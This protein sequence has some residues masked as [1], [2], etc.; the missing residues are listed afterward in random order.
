MY[1]EGRGK[2]LC[3]VWIRCVR[4]LRWVGRVWWWRWQVVR[5][6][7][8]PRGLPRVQAALRGVVSSRVGVVALGIRLLVEAVQ[9]LVVG[10]VVGFGARWLLPPPQVVV[11]PVHGL[12]AC[13]VGWWAVLVVVWLVVVVVVVVVVLVML[14]AYALVVVVVAVVVVF[15]VLVAVVVVV[16]VVP[17]VVVVV[18]L[19]LCPHDP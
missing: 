15:G 1:G 18:V 12:W 9:L 8:Y 5:V 3:P 16:V 14:V 4:G 6:Q 13:G 17:G 19:P 10:R 2:A 11:V 7:W